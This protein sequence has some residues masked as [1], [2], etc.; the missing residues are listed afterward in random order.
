MATDGDA[1]R[2][3]SEDDMLPDERE[4]IAERVA[5]LDD[6]DEDEYLSVVEMAESLDIELD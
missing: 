5:D 1:S 4:V 6:L 3:P 2:Q